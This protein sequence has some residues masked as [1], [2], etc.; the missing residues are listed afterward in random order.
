MDFKTLLKLPKINI[1]LSH[2]KYYFKS[3]L[4]IYFFLVIN[5]I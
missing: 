5:E 3:A 4:M 1:F 2:F